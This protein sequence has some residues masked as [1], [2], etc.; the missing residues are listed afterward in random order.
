LEPGAAGPFEVDAQKD[1]FEVDAQQ[2]LLKLILYALV[3]ASFIMLV[4]AGAIPMLQS[5]VWYIRHTHDIV[6]QT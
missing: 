1:P 3:M 6:H 4:S 5:I 2:E